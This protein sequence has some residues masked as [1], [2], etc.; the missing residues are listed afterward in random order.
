MSMWKTPGQESGRIDTAPLPRAHTRTRFVDLSV[1]FLGSG[2]ITR[3]VSRVL[4]E[5]EIRVRVR[6]P[7]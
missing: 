6:V 5:T 2:R 1:G 7:R 4:A 3:Q